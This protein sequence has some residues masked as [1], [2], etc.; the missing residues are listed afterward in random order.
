[1]WVF[2]FKYYGRISF[3]ITLTIFK[4]LNT[5]V[6]LVAT[7][8]G[9]VQTQ[10]ISII[11]ENYFGQCDRSLCTD[12]CTPQFHCRKLF[13]TDRI[14]CLLGYLLCKSGE[15]IRIY[16]HICLNTHKETLKRYMEIITVVP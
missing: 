11:A 7:V 6:W 2:K 10:N 3:S 13:L 4:V 8:Y 15:E 12:T 16:S 5:H 9:S 1:M 14:V